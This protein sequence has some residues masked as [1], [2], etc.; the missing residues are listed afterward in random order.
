MQTDAVPDATSLQVVVDADGIAAIGITDFAQ[1]Q[2]GDIV[3][4]D[5]PDVGDEI[6]LD[7]EFA[8]VE[9]VKAA[10]DLV[11]PVSGEVTEVNDALGDSPGLMNTAPETDGYKDFDIAL[12][13]SARFH[14]HRYRSAA[15]RGP[16][17][18]ARYVMLKSILS[19]AMCFNWGFRWVIKVKISDIAEFDQLMDRDEYTAYCQD[20]TE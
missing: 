4:V 2:L 14:Q 15:L 5:S 1:D 16:H 9:S 17:H 8:V 3:W 10:S 20:M 18:A 7:D 6:D 12:T 19:A 13:H 11:A